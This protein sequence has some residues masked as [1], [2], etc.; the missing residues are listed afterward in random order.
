MD[1]IFR[2]IDI[3]K[4]D[5]IINS[6]LEEFSKNK[7]D[8]ASTNVIVKNAGISKGLLFHYFSNK[9]ELYKK[10][11][12]FVI[13]TVKDTVV[14]N[15]DWN[16]TDFFE[17]MKQISMIKVEVTYR[18]PYIYDFFSVMVE[19]KTLEKV[20]E[21]NEVYNKEL[22]N[23]IYTHNIDFSM[24]RDDIDIDMIM[25]IT[26]WVFEKFGDELFK[27]RLKGDKRFNYK[28]IEIE[29]EKYI[30]ILKKAFYKH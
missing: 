13:S 15:I 16:I 9:Q 23:R 21:N 7:F 29:I 14:D 22:I 11:E 28:E 18:Y 8:K 2:N 3:E 25:K 20:R 24:F 10:L 4:R 27:N 17:R 26:N 30:D 6:A 19:E 12:K 5:R 1:E